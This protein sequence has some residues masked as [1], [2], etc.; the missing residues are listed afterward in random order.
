MTARH[1]T[2]LPVIIVRNDS[3]SGPIEKI[4]RRVETVTPTL[5]AILHFSDRVPCHP[6]VPTGVIESPLRLLPYQPP[7]LQ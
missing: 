3:L 7:H 4:H 1:P 2:K 6:G 5:E